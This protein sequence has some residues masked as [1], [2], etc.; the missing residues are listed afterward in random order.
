MYASNKDGTDTYDP[1]E[2]GFEMYIQ[3]DNK[4]QMSILSKEAAKNIP[5]YEKYFVRVNKYSLYYGD[6]VGGYRGIRNSIQLNLLRGSGENIAA[7]QCCKAVSPV[8]LER[9][10]L[11][12]TSTMNLYCFSVSS[13]VE[14]WKLCHE[15][16][17]Q[18]SSFPKSHNFR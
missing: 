4:Q 3:V 7:G 14:D 9:D 15:D 17:T 5:D 18:A 12:G 10:L 2:I 6:Q 13:E 16:K 8:G 1:S 11:I